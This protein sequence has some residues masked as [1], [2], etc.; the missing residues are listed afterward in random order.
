MFERK[1]VINADNGFHTRPAAQFVK[2]AKTYKSKIMVMY[3]DAEASAKSLF[4]LQ[5]LGI[6]EGAEICIRAEGDDENE[7]VHSLVEFIAELK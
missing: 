2:Q 1:V 3:N 6:V 5:T 7:S 4:K